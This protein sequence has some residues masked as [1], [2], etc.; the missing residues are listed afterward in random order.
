[1]KSTSKLVQEIEYLE[2]RERV[3]KGMRRFG[4]L[5]QIQEQKAEAQKELAGRRKNGKIN[6]FTGHMGWD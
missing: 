4:E 2:H 6:Y 1:M 3:L 5:K